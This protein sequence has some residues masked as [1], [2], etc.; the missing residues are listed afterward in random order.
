MSGSEAAGTRA[1]FW[2]PHARIGVDRCSSVDRSFAG[3]FDPTLALLEREV[4]PFRREP[5]SRC[6]SI[7]PSSN[8]GARDPMCKVSGQGNERALYPTR[9]PPLADHFRGARGQQENSRGRRIFHNEAS[10]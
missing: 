4:S 10:F 2:H 8:L 7:H 5:P 3:G 6:P 1:S 9:V